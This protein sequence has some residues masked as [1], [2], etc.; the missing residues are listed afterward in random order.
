MASINF[1]CLIVVI[2][3]TKFQLQLK[4]KILILE[5]LS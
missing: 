5:F 4:E 3:F 1:D 2:L